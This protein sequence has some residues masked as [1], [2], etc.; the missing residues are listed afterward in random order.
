MSAVDDLS[1]LFRDPEFI[2]FWQETN[3]TEAELVQFMADVRD[4]PDE[5]RHATLLW[6]A[7]S[8]YW[9]PILM[10]C[11]GWQGKI[12][13][14]AARALKRE[15]AADT[16]GKRWNG[17]PHDVGRASIERLLGMRDHPSH[18][19]ACAAF[20]TWIDDDGRSWIAG[21]VG[22]PPILSRGISDWLHLD[23]SDVVLWDPR[24]NETRLVG[25]HQSTANFV[26][27][28]IVDLRVTLWADGGA[29]FRAWAARRARKAD[30]FRAVSN[31]KWKHPVMEDRDSGLPG[32]LVIGDI[33]RA[34]WPSDALSG[35]SAVTAGPGLTHA[36]L[37]HCAVRS[38]NFP[39]FEGGFVDRGA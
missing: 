15:L 19:Y 21:A 4:A 22:A 2:R 32:G 23:I 28:E 30:L 34:R 16:P 37:H 8:P 36:E 18:I 35:V 1:A 39:R 31:G 5:D 11:G 6:W 27:P 24:T 20:R 9:S 25:E 38:A 14:N 29:F 33:G 13:R 3:E 12:A 26:L 10:M 7:R 17:L